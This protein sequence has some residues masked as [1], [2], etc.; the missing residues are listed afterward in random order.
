VRIPL[1][2]NL[3]ALLED[4]EL[5]K[6]AKK[7]LKDS[8]A[9]FLSLLCIDNYSH[10]KSKD[11]FRRLNAE[12]L[13][14]ILGR[15]KGSTR[16]SRKVKDILLK[17]RVIEKINY[18]TGKYSQGF[19]L[20]EKYNIGEFKQHQIGPS[21]GKRLKARGYSEDISGVTSLKYKVLLEQFKNHKI[22]ID[23]VKFEAFIRNLGF[24]ILKRF[25]LERK[26]KLR[27]IKSLFN[28]I[29]RALQI[30]GDVNAKQFN[31]KIG[32]SNGRF[33]SF[34]TSL[35][36]LFRPFILIDGEKIGEVDIKASQPYILATILNEEFGESILSGFTLST[37][38]PEFV[39]VIKNME[40]INPTRKEINTERIIGLYVSKEDL[41]GIK[42]F[43]DIEFNK[44]FY[45]HVIEQGKANFPEIVKRF[46]KSKNERDYVKEKI[47]QFLFD[48]NELNRENNDVVQLVQSIY[49]ELGKIIKTFN[50]FYSG[51]ELAILLQKAEVYLIIS[52]AE[53]LKKEDKEIPFFT[54][55]DSIITQQKHIEKVE[56]ILARIIKKETK[57]E[58]GIKKINLEPVKKISDEGLKER[59]NKIKIKSKKNWENNRTY[60]LKG[61]IKRGIEFLFTGDKKELSYWTSRLDNN[62]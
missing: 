39:Q 11:G 13:D 46:K 47:M 48:R 5:R 58:V 62:Y 34:L 33:Y 44:D 32:E 60:I 52:V 3:D 6:D 7:N 40:I 21:L 22:E 24:S 12:V 43:V 17:N 20:A 49:P 50:E 37:I 10:V 26:Q 4:N 29:G 14:D 55:H 51:K 45:Q 61:N 59:M 30:V 23:K 1:N 2:V 27:S 38:Y 36:R 25:K 16:R 53:A 8:C 42:K 41:K 31:Q 18:R 28:Y 54:I 57:K 19:R 35:P 9:Y 56:E 15:G